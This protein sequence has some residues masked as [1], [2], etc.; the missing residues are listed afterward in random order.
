MTTS[1]ALLVLISL[2]LMGMWGA[3]VFLRV[4]LAR[5]DKLANSSSRYSAAMQDLLKE[6]VEW[7]ESVLTTL[8]FWNDVIAKKKFSR[9]LALA[10]LQIKNGEQYPIA[11]PREKDDVQAFMNMHAEF[12]TKYIAVLFH[13]LMTISYY[14]LFWGFIIR[15]T[16]AELLDGDERKNVEV[17]TKKVR[18]NI[19]GS[20][21]LDL[22]NHAAAAA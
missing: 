15:S 12:K 19:K 22:D 21:K 13:A 5:L 18:N 9:M 7:P 10:L 2:I 8:H 4:D 16:I 3:R 1:F 6:E 11:G 20:T 17:F 14:N